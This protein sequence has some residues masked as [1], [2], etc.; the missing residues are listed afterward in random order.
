M[1]KY[2]T[3]ETLFATGLL[4]FLLS[5]C[6]GKDQDLID[7]ITGKTGGVPVTGVSLDKAS[8][9]LKVGDSKTLTA[10]VAPEDA[11]NKNVSWTS[12]DATIATVE[13]GR[14]TGVK[15]GS[16]T[17]TAKTEDGGM[18]AECAVTVKTNLAPSVTVGA[19]HI[20]AV[21]VVLKGEAN[22]DAQMS[23]DMTMGIMWSENSGVLPSNSTK[24]EAKDIDAKEGSTTSY[25]YSV[26]LTGLDPEKTYYF[27]SYVT[28]NSQDTYGE[29]KSFTAKSLIA[30]VHA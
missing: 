13:N 23:S 18:T 30:A 27:R 10:T 25:C 11:T 26:N 12:G 5:A 16:V 22:L 7:S 2:F 6:N 17:I 9:E 20:S 29:T 14:V 19:E 1:K 8:L 15:P 28:Q 24:I 3:L 21:S 4:L